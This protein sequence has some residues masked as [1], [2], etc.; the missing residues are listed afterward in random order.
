MQVQFGDIFKEITFSK[1]TETSLSLLINEKV[2][3][4]LSSHIDVM[5]IKTYKVSYV[6]AIAN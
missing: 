1:V 5:H 6:I 2:L 4:N 3:F